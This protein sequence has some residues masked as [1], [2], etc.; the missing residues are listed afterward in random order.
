MK[1][2]L[3]GYEV[4]SGAEVKVPIR[5]TCVLGQ[6]QESGKTTTQEA[7]ITRSGLR[8]VAFLTK[9]GEQS[10]RLSRPIA[11]FFREAADDFYR[12]VVAVIEGM[13]EMKLSFDATSLILKL[14]RDYSKTKGT[15]KKKQTVYEWDA[16]DSLEAVMDNIRAAMPFLRGREE[17]TAMAIEEHLKRVLPEIKAA[18]FA[19]TLK[20]RDGIN[21]MDITALSPGL[22]SLVVSSEI[23]W[24]RQRE[25]GTIVIIPEAW[26]FIP[27]GRTSPVKRAAERLMREGA[28]IQ[29]YVWI[30]SQDLRGVDKALLRSVAVWYFGVQRERNEITNTLNS[31]PALPKPSATDIMG[32]KKGQFYVAFGDTLVKTYVRP[33]GMEAEQARAIARGEE[34]AD[35]WK[36]IVRTLE[37]ISDEE[38]DKDLSGAYATNA[39]TEA[40]RLSGHGRRVEAGGYDGD[41]DEY[42]DDEIA[43]DTC[44]RCGTPI[45]IEGFCTEDECLEAAAGEPGEDAVDAKNTEAGESGARDEDGGMESGHPRQASTG[46]DDSTQSDRN[47]AVDQTAAQGESEKRRP[48]DV[49]AVGSVPDGISEN[50]PVHSTFDRSIS[51]ATLIEGDDEMWKERAEAAEKALDQ[52]RIDFEQLRE[53]HDLTAERLRKMLDGPN[54]SSLPEAVQLPSVA[55]PKNGAA[56]ISHSTPAATVVHSGGL[57]VKPAPVSDFPNGGVPSYNDIWQYVCAR[58]LSEKPVL[59][60]LLQDRPELE[61]TVERRTVQIDGESVLGRVALLI[62]ERFFDNE[63][64]PASIRKEFIRRGWLS[65]KRGFS[66]LQPSIAKLTEMGFLTN[67]SGSFKAVESM[68]INVVKA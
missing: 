15:G 50:A 30:D 64:A 38:S 5:H 33:A 46:E 54:P 57:Q 58:A 20:I 66:D 65:D 27:E 44:I 13:L 24:V 67:E 29:N 34:S 25:K 31:L 21:V 47:R 9:R 63:A 11:P 45:P 8:A 12:Y 42:Q 51:D 39:A 4:G 37:E 59:L 55:V 3:V 61:V 56:G 36:S 19:E 60:K 17:N 53:S 28:G 52:L 43:E 26:K 6:T 32:L 62:K 48:T 16:A 10:F 2:I 49:G 41:A 7:M 14:C 22:Q 35:S 18:N 68:K 23:D 1:E 40:D